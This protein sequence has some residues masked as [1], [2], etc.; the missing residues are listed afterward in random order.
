MRRFAI[1]ALALPLGAPACDDDSPTGPR[2]G[3]IVFTADLRHPTKCRRSATPSQWAGNRRRSRSA[4]RATAQATSP[5]TATWNVQAIV[6]GFTD[7]SRIQA[8]H[9]H[10]GA[11]GVRTPASSSNTGLTTANAIPVNVAPRSTSKA[12]Q[13]SQAQAQAVIANPAGHYFNMHTPLNPGGAVTG[14]AGARAVAAVRSG[15]GASEVHPAPYAP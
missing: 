8:A 9:I 10:N 3:P 13:I 5:A 11:A 7:D 4:C 15:Q 1:F 12:S 6:S 2:T 14:P